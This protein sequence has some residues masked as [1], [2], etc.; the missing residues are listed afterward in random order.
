MPADPYR[1]FLEALR[2]V[3]RALPRR[4]MRSLAGPTAGLLALLVPDL[5][6]DD[7]AV[8]TVS[9]DQLSVQE[10][11]RAFL[12]A[13]ARDRPCVLI[14][15]DMRWADQA[16]LA[17]LRHVTHAGAGGL[18][19]LATRGSTAPRTSNRFDRCSPSCA[20]GAP[21]ST[22]NSGALILWTSAACS[23]AA[24][25]APPTSSRHCIARPVAIR[26]SS[27]I[28]SVSSYGMTTYATG[29]GVVT[30]KM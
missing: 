11:V 13:L 7:V 1:P 16:S 25:V 9:G 10:A 2:Q 23:A 4:Q 8:S 3:D 27:T 21:S 17:L 26:S 14:L 28:W 18:L 19:I 5:R 22:S 12:E 29:G 15:E 30:S 20:T 6:T 24:G